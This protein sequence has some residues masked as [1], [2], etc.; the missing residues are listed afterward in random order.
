MKQYIADL[1]RRLRPSDNPYLAALRD[2]SFD[3]DDFLETQIQF[4]FAVVFFSRPMAALAGRLPRPELRLAL[5]DVEVGEVAA[6]SEEECTACDIDKAVAVLRSGL[7]RLLA[8]ARERPR[9]EL[10][11]TST[12]AGAE[13]RLGARLLGKTPVERPAWAGRLELEV[14]LPGYE[15]QRLPVTVSPGETAAVNVPLQPE[16]AEP[17]PSALVS[18]APVNRYGTK[19]RP[20]WRLAVGGVAVVGGALLTGFGA[21]ALAVSDQCVEEARAPVAF[22]RERYGTSS[23]GTGLV[24]S[25]AAVLVTGTLLLA[26]PERR[27]KTETH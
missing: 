5:L 17:P 8:T 22:C 27:R 18:S 21:S 23:I 1:K 10:K 2:G 12:P 6:R 9:G 13:V 4:L 3:R 7:P 24:I 20:R 15:S 25:G 16:L 19:S 26:I 11:V 14:T